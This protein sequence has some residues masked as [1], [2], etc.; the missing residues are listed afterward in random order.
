MCEKGAE[1]VVLGRTSTEPRADVGQQLHHVGFIGP[2]T[3]A[4]RKMSNQGELE[5]AMVA[6]RFEILAAIFKTARAATGAG[7]TGPVSIC[8]SHPMRVLI[9]A[10]GP[11]RR[12][13][14][15]ALH[16]ENEG[17]DAISSESPGRIHRKS[18][19]TLM[20]KGRVSAAGAKI[21]G[22]NDTA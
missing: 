2:R 3:A 14:F 12:I 20:L 7:A 1:K 9:T 16:S 8:D 15:D 18:V 5:G 6:F 17:V 10:T 19:S 22:Y 21:A 11:A 4:C 13:Q